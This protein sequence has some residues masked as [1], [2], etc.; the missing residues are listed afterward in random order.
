MASDGDGQKSARNLY[1]FAWDF[2]GGRVEGVFAAT[3]EEVAAAIG[4]EAYFGEV[5][6]KH[7]E[8]GGS[9]G[10]DDISLVT[11]DQPFVTKAVE[12][13]V[14]PFGLN[15]LT[16][17]R[18]IECGCAWGD[19]EDDCSI[20]KAKAEVSL[21]ACLDEEDIA[22]EIVPNGPGVAEAVDRLVHR[23]LEVS[24]QRE[25]DPQGD[26]GWSEFARDEDADDE[27]PF[28]SDAP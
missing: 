13:G 4:R 9:I 2:R 5:L 17:L 10:V 1:R 24:D 28:G 18:C 19:H 8:V 27:P 26:H 3:A 7:S 25:I 11:D 20:G 22:I 23:A 21:T 15:P 6:G 12:L 14:V 16:H